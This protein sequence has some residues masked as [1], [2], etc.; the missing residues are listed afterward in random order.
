[1]KKS[2]K[3]APGKL[4]AEAQQAGIRDAAVREKTGKSWQEWFTVLDR[5]G[6]A[7]MPHREIAAYVDENYEVSPW[8]GQMV[9]VAYEQARGLRRLRAGPW[10]AAQASK[11]GWLRNRAQ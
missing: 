10:L 1:M 8:W 4:V 3:K 6:C 2:M 5:A 9:T 11:A 7:K